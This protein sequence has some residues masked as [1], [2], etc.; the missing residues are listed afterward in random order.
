MADICEVTKDDVVLDPACGSG[1]FLVACMDRLL[2]EHHL[3]REQMVKIVKTHLIGFEDEPV[4][5][6]LCVANMI[7]RGDGST[8]IHRADALKSRSAHPSQQR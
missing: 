3:S 6:A 7:L 1:G 2:R 5:A 8:G 4:T